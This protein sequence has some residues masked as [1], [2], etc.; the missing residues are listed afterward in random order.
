MYVFYLLQD[1]YVYIYIYIYIYTHIISYVYII[2]RDVT[3]NH[4]IVSIEYP[5]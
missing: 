1:D 3:G 5:K 2:Y 4:G